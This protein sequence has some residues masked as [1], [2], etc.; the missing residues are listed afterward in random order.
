MRINSENIA[1]MHY[2]SLCLSLVYNITSFASI[3]VVIS[4]DYIFFFFYKVKKK[5]I[6]KK[7]V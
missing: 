7:N 4:N 1:R 6:K 2:D 5:D 3:A